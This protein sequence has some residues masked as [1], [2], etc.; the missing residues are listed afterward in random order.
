MEYDVTQK[1]KW[2]QILAQHTIVHL[3]TCHISLKL[4]KNY[5]QCTNVGTFQTLP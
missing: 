2:A 3:A 5:V 1:I 4:D